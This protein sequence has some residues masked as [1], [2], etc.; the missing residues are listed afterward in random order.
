MRLKY[1]QAS[2]STSSLDKYS[3]VQIPPQYIVKQK[4]AH[5]VQVEPLFFEQHEWISAFIIIISLFVQN[6]RQI[7]RYKCRLHMQQTR[8]K[9]LFTRR[10]LSPLGVGSIQGNHVQNVMQIVYEDLSCLEDRWEYV[11]MTIHAAKMQ[12]MR[13]K[14]HPYQPNA[15]ITST[16][17]NYLSSIHPKKQ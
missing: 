14:W 10:L 11:L 13:F 6:A 12:H 15:S 5:E 16:L 4:F 8:M 7:D 2:F 9:S 17:T 1:S 3:K